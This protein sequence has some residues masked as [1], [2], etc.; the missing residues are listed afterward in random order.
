MAIDDWLLDELVAGRSGPVL[1]L[2]RWSRPT[3]SLGWH[4]RSLQ[5]HWADLPAEAGIELVRRPSGGRAVLHAGCLTYALLWPDP[6]ASRPLAYRQA[7]AWLR[8]A[9]AVLGQPLL[10]GTAAANGQRSSCFATSTAADLVHAGGAKRVGSAQLWRRGRLLQHGSLLLDP[11]ETLWRQVF[12]QPPPLLPPM[13]LPDQELETLLLRT[14]VTHLVEGELI[15]R[16]LESRE[17]AQIE[18]RRERY[19]WGEAGT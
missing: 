4:Q 10:L 12:G 3:L 17:L 7:C 14:A 13:P 16:P 8:E 19:R 2:Y 15:S 11:P 1:R 5:P 9:F 6:P 18:A